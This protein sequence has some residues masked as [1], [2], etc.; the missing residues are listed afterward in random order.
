MVLSAEEINRLTPQERLDL[1]DRLWD[2]LQDEE[3]SL[4][5]EQAA[6][7]DRRLATFDEDMKEA[8]TWEEAKKFLEE[9]RR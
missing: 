3:F 4:T 7:L 8:V 5:P 1:I 9:R 2:S 6:E